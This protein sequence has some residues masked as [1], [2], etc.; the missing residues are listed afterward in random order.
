MSTPSAMR[1]FLLAGLA[2]AAAVGAC[3]PDSSGIKRL[4]LEPGSAPA[5]ITITPSAVS[6][7]YIGATERLTAQVLDL[8]GKPAPGLSFV[9]SSSNT[10]VA[11]VAQDGTVTA[12]SEGSAVIYARVLNLVDSAD[13]TVKRIPAT[14]ELEPTDVLFTGLG[15]TATIAATVLDGGGQPLSN[16]EIVWSSTDTTVVTVNGSGLLTAV[17]QG[18][19]SV[20]ATAG[21]IQRTVAVRVA[22]GPATVVVSPA[23]LAFDALGDTTRLSA[24]VLNAAGDTL[25]GVSVTFLNGDTA[26]AVV[27]SVGLVTAVGVGSTSLV[28]EGD[29]VRT[30]VPVTVTQTPA[31]VDVTPDS[32][33]LTPG[34]SLTFS[35]SVQDRNGNDITSPTLSWSSSEV[36]VATVTGTGTVTAVAAG[37]AFIIAMAGTVSDSAVVTVVDVPVDSVSLTPD[38]VTLEQGDTTTLTVRFFDASGTELIGPA[39]TWSSDDTGVATVTQTGLVT[40]VD[41]GSTWI[42][43]T[44]DSAVDSTFV[45]VTPS[46]A[47]APLLLSSA[48]TDGGVA[49][50][51][52]GPA[53]TQGIRKSPERGILRE[54]GA[55][56]GQEGVRRGVTALGGEGPH[57]VRLTL[58]V[59]PEGERAKE[60]F[61]FRVPT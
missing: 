24:V 14:L 41:T 2:L 28:V 1:R 12:V 10:A 33:T 56:Q 29:T 20:K 36:A 16:D 11:T 51:G 23:T 57:Q 25:S 27:D 45:T 26:V 52:A 53:H 35:A 13:V 5:R 61:R 37:S 40:A 39:A 44:A 43:A 8:D 15:D 60:R 32:A 55:R 7:G 59:P 48:R 46:A 3:N 4:P 30:S 21:A 6:L 54:G 49:G 18:N 31:A 19:A 47:P 9:W 17:G 22:T 42:R 58:G 50:S 38:S 34:G